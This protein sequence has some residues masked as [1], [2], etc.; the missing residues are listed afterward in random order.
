[1]ALKENAL[2]TN[3]NH[4]AAEVGQSDRLELSD[5]RAIR[6]FYDHTCLKCSKKPATSPDHVIPLADGGTNTRSNIQ[7][8]CT[9]CNKRKGAKHTDYRDGRICPNDYVDSRT[10]A[11]D[12]YGAKVVAERVERWKQNRAAEP[13]EYYERGESVFV[14]AVLDAVRESPSD[15][16]H[17]KGVH[18][19]LVRS[20]RWLQKQGE[21][22]HITPELRAQVFNLTNGLCFWCDS[23]LEKGWHCDHFIPFSR[24]GAT[25]LENLVPA[26]PSCNLR[27]QARLPNEAARRKYTRLLGNIQAIGDLQENVGQ[28]RQVP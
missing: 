26:C 11:L 18:N 12:E 23:R 21:R 2:V 3:L 13:Y 28:S 4:R 1:M 20:F 27:K 16:Q 6:E 9:Q 17:K 10:R 7:L 15:E 24:G 8:L 5:I 14:D 25:S 19:L 22:Q